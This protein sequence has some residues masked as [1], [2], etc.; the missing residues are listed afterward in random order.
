MEGCSKAGIR[1]DVR[2]RGYGRM[3][4]GGDKEGCS[5]AGIR[6]DVRRRG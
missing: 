6:K 4:E 3:F 5:K 2:R 1:K